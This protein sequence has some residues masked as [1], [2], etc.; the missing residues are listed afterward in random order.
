MF[1][2]LI[3]KI[4]LMSVIGMISFLSASWSLKRDA[5]NQSIELQKRFRGEK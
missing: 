2:L 4:L 1:E 5:R 3:T